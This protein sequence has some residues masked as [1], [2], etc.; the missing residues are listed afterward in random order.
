MEKKRRKVVFRC[1][2]VSCRGGLGCGGRWYRMS[3]KC[4]PGMEKLR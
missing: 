2:G 4:G 3:Q 1:L